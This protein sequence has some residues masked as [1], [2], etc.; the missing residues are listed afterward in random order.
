MADNDSL[1]FCR[2]CSLHPWCFRISW[3]KFRKSFSYIWSQ[4]RNGSRMV[5]ISNKTL[6]IF[7]SERWTSLLASFITS[8]IRGTSYFWIRCYT[9]EFVLLRWVLLLDIDWNELICCSYSRSSCRVHIFS[10]YKH[11]IWFMENE[12]N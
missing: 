10:W 5:R 8:R 3:T 11:I 6:L 2:R 7:L 4:F 1:T 9:N 12:I